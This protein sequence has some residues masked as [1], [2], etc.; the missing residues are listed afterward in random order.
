MQESQIT[1]TRAGTLSVPAARIILAE[2]MPD[3][4]LVSVVIPTCGRRA[5][6]EPCLDALAAQTYPHVEVVVVDDGST[7]DTSP[8]LAEY[9]SEHDELDLTVLCNEHRIGAN[10]SR[11]R[12]IRASRGEFIAFT[13]DD[14]IADARWIE[15]LVAAFDSDD[16]AAVTGRVNDPRPTNIYELTFK[17]THRLAAGRDATRLVAGN[18]CLPRPIICKYMLDEDRGGA[19][20]DITVSGRGDEDGLYQF[21][22]ADGLK[23]RTAHDAI[24]LHEHHYTGRAFFRQAYRSGK[25]TARLG[26]KYRLTWRIELVTLM[27]AWLLL[28]VVMLGGAWWLVP[29][30]PAALFLAAITYNELFRKRKNILE[31]IIIYP[32]LLVYYHLRLVGYLVQHYRLLAGKDRIQRVSG[33]RATDRPAPMQ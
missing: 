2:V 9:K 7:D 1:S 17:G 12:G 33:S 32:M 8:F 24:V 22:K 20:S 30:I 6:L 11:N 13:D 23:V 29:A 26:Y 5:V 10:P 19:Q 18:M 31:L 25:A 21:L 15:R 3:E 27:V 14:C 4:P 16:V 28:P